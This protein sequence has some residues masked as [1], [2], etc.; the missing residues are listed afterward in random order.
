MKKLLL[1]ASLL[2][3]SLVL[4]AQPVPV[5]QVPVNGQYADGDFFIDAGDILVTGTANYWGESGSFS[6]GSNSADKPKNSQFGLDLGGYRG[7]NEN[8]A[9][10]VHAGISGSTFGSEDFGSGSS[11]T[12][13]SKTMLSVGVGHFCPIPKT[14]LTHQ[15][16]IQLPILFGSE[17]T[18][19]VGSGGN[20]TTSKDNLSGFGVSLKGSLLYSVDDNWSIGLNY[21][22]A[23]FT[24]E[25]S[26]A[27]EG[28]F[29]Q[30]CN[31]LDFNYFGRDLSVSVYRSF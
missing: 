28:D 30:T 17:E 6:S 31:H 16:S 2:L 5:D 7:I 26:K 24:S 1:F 27:D 13:V 11:E 20:A 3:F 4:Y 19:H 22:G 10:G 21:A 25:K 12:K 29:E 18:E 14:R 15:T 23:T 9:V 8:L